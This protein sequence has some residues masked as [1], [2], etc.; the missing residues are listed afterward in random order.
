[1]SVLTLNCGSSSV[2]YS[3]YD[4]ARRA[5]LARGGV[6]RVGGADSFLKEKRGARELRLEEATPDH[7]A[8]VRLVLRALGEGE[9]APVRD[10]RAIRA[11]GHRAVHG[12]ERFAQSALVTDELVRTLEE[13]SVLAPLHNP[14]NL[15]GIR[16]AQA[17]LPGV[18]QVAVFDTAFHQS[19][20]REAFLYALPMAWYEKHGIRRYGFHGTSHLYVSRRAAVVLGRPLAG[21]RLVTLHIGN[22]ASAAAVLG[23]RS[24]DT[25]MGFTPLEG[26]VM[27]T[28]SGTIDPAIPL[29]VMGREQLG[30]AQMDTQ[31]NKKSGLLGIT[32]RFNDRR[33]IEAAAA[34]GD[35]DCELAIA[36]ECRALAKTVGAFAA[37]MGGLDAVVF[38]A[39]VGEN[40]ATIR[41]RA[42]APLAFLGVQLDED[43]NRAARGGER[44][45]DIATPASRVRVLVVPTNE[46]LVIAEDTLGIV[47]GR[48]GQPGFRY[49]FE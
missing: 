7:V 29:Y 17:L 48:F 27:G 39:G 2:K 13:L 32:G 21:L 38:T 37:V 22:G 26:L 47:E 15:A 35:A 45:L 12:G 46:E 11:V 49:S 19:M 25:S 23:G 10:P 40:S 4:P 41:A 24:V 3:V 1:M 18:P 33:D 42:M 20:P 9:D 16:A 5:F 8:A 44:E 31:L 6:E 14:P 34:Q 36:L 43:K 28:R 30:A